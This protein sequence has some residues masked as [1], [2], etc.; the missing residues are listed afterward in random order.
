MIVFVGGD[1]M[2]RDMVCVVGIFILVLGI[3]AGVK[4]YF[5]VYVVYV[6]GVVEIIVKMFSF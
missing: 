2:A 5:G 3:L 6:C 4:I 1:G